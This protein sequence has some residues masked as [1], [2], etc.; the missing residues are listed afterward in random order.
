MLNLTILYSGLGKSARGFAFCRGYVLINF[1][2]TISILAIIVCFAKGFTAT[3]FW[4]FLLGFLVRTG[5]IGICIGLGWLLVASGLVGGGGL[6]ASIDDVDGPVDDGESEGAD[7]EADEGVENGFLGFLDFA[8]VAGRGNIVDSAHDDENDSNKAGD[9][10]DGVEDVGDSGGELVG[11]AAIT[12]GG[13]S[14]CLWDGL[15]AFVASLGK[16]WLSDKNR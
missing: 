3:I 12:A 1:F 11:I 15:I 2:P 7:D 8:G 4:Y 16:S 14:D 13:F 6:V 9:G 5:L 10:D